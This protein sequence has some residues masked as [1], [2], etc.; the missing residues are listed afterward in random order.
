MGGNFV[1][2]LLH[3]LYLIYVCIF[4]HTQYESLHA[5]VPVSNT[6]EQL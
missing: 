2:P 4:F 5:I 1:H 6:Y 3:W